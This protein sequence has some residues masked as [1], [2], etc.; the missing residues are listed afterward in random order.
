M[1]TDI[2]VA[3]IITRFSMNESINIS[4]LYMCDVLCQMPIDHSCYNK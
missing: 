2:L 1:F 4:L 3:F